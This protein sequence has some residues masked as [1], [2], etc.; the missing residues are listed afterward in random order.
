MKISIKPLI[1]EVY[2]D[3]VL[4]IDSIHGPSHWARVLQ[5]GLLLSKL[6]IGANV[7]VITLFAIFH[8]SRRVNESIDDGHG[9]RGGEY[10]KKFRNKYF[11]L[12]DDEFELLYFACKA[13]TDGMTEADI[14]V[15][16]CW[17][18]DRLDIGRA[19]LYPDPKYLCTNAAKDPNLIAKANKRSVEGFMPSIIQEE[20]GFDL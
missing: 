3:F 12:S 18:A 8:D 14:T 11:D 2:N 4:S 9:L 17:D 16:I 5:N 13:H 7:K 1:K 19:N 6:S 20:W 15:Q 10:V